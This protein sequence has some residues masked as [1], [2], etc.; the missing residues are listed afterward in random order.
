MKLGQIIWSEK[1]SRLFIEL[2]QL[3]VELLILIFA[4]CHYQQPISYRQR[5]SIADE[6]AHHENPELRL[7][8]TGLAHCA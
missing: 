4:S 6:T 5:V 1:T 8:S 3:R 7:R 2:Q